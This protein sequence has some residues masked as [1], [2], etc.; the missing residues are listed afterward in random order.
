[1]ASLYELTGNYLQVYDME[2]ID[3]ETWFETLESIDEAIEDKAENYAKLI[4]NIEADIPGIDSE[5]KRLQQMKS[6]AQN[7]V[8]RLKENLQGSMEVVGKEKFKSGNF[9]FNIQNNPSSAQIPDESLIPKKYFVKQEPKLDRKAVLAALKEGTKV[10]GAEL[11]Q[12]RS[13][14]IR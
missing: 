9:S 5:I 1:M 13:L 14:R 7:K 10:R 2:E 4:K 6:T 12:G 3:S 8:K 11:Y